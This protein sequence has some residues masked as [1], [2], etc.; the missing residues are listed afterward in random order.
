MRFNK[1]ATS[2]YN[3]SISCAY[4]CSHRS[5]YPIIYTFAVSFIHIHDQFQSTYAL[6]PFC[7][8]FFFVFPQAAP[9]VVDEVKREIEAVKSKISENTVKQALQ[10]LR[11]LLSRPPG[12]F[13]VHSAMAALEHLSDIGRENGDEHVPRYNAILKQT[14]GLSGHQAIQRILL[15]LLGTKEEI[16][17]A[18]EIEKAT[19]SNPLSPPLFSS[20][21][22]NG[23]RPPARARPYVIT[24]YACG[25]RGNIARNCRARRGRNFERY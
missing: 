11:Q 3:R 6:L 22:S 23:Q 5:P 18:K 19:K 13:D 10:N 21:V 1:L 9:D 8:S 24:C 2:L 14:R 16:A 4:L 17:I 12:V 25:L 7:L 20:Q 15:K